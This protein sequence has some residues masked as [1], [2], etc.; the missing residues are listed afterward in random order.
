MSVKGK[1]PNG[2][3]AEI[4][5]QKVSQASLARSL[6]TSRQQISRYVDGT[7]RL[8]RDWAVRFGKALHCP[9]ERLLF[10]NEAAEPAVVEVPLLSWVS[11]GEMQ[12]V[13]QVDVEPRKWLPV[14]GLGRGDFFALEVGGDSMDLISPDGSTIVVDRSRRALKHGRPYV[15]QNGNETTYKLWNETL[16]MLMPYSSNRR[17][18]PIPV[19]E[20][21]FHVIGAVRRTMLDF[22]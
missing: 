13:G 21:S 20:E 17:H 4:E 8:D 3:R 18:E 10:E 9:P 5:A 22:S 7:Y 16:R 6:G 2:L 11:A 14:A 19:R 12:D 1:Y 15:F